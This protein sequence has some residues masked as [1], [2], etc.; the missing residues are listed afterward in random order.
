[1]FRHHPLIF[2]IF[3]LDWLF[4]GI[5]ECRQLF[6]QRSWKALLHSLLPSGF[7]DKIPAIWLFS[8]FKSL[9]FTLWVVCLLLVISSWEVHNVMCCL[10]ILLSFQYLFWE[11]NKPFQSEAYIFIQQWGKYINAWFFFS[12]LLSNSLFWEIS[13]LV[14]N[15][16]LCVSSL[17]LS[18]S[19]LFFFLIQNLRVFLGFLFQPYC[20]C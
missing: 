12:A 20:S 15:S 9:C 8:L 2:S 14:L 7:T 16:I 5:R 13:S 1:M 18:V 3:K 10:G 19:H 4:E 17:L 6:F 11:I